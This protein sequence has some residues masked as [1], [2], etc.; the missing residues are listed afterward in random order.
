MGMVDHMKNPGKPHHNGTP[1]FIKQ[2]EISR[3]H[4]N[5]YGIICSYQELILMISAICSIRNTDV[6]LAVFNVH[7]RF[8][9]FVFKHQSFIFR[10]KCL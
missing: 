2:V 3:H 5:S 10:L 7:L 4:G 8:I 1:G 9:V 6:F